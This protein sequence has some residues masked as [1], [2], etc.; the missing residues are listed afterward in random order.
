M[1]D[2]RISKLNWLWQWNQGSP[3]ST[4]PRQETVLILYGSQRG[5]AER[6]AESIVSQMPE[7]LS[8]EAIATLTDQSVD[9]EVVPKLMTLNDFIADPEWTRLVVIVVSSF[10][11][12]D[13]PMN[14]RQFRKWC[15]RAQATQNGNRILS[16]IR[17]AMLGLGDSYYKTYMGNPKAIEA[18]LLA[19]GAERVGERGEADA[20]KGK[21]EQEAAMAAW[22]DSI[23]LE[24]ARVLVEE[25]LA[26]DVLAE[27]KRQTQKV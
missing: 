10:G 11:A 26:E 22:I 12:G 14:A 19:A 24:L 8:A 6:T 13:A 16:G 17:F 27:M 25:P 2:H 15:D 9:V 4:M 20:D 23:W 21:G 3:S 5:T 18:G 7:K 1:I